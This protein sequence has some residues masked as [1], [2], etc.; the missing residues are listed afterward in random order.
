MKDTFCPS[1]HQPAEHVAAK[2]DDATMCKNFCQEP[3]VEK[4]KRGKRK[5]IMGAPS[6]R[7]SVQQPPQFSFYP[8]EDR[9]SLASFY[10][11]MASEEEKANA[12]ASPK[13]KAKGKNNN[14]GMAR[15]RGGAQR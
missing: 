5:E 14:K 4:V 9:E 6:I 11:D 15:R 13:G 10:E 2:D 1:L 8:E 3:P 7:K 12:K